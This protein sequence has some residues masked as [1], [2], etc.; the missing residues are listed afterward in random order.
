MPNQLLLRSEIDAFEVG[1]AEKVW[2]IL[3]SPKIRKTIIFK[4]KIG[5][6]RFSRF[7]L[8]S[9]FMTHCIKFGPCGSKSLQINIFVFFNF[10]KSW[11]KNMKIWRSENSH[12]FVKKKTYKNG[13][14]PKS[15]K[16]STSPISIDDFS[17]FRTF[18]CF[19]HFFSLFN[20][21]RIYLRAHEEL[22]GQTVIVTY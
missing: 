20:F 12:F 19:S 10:E 4:H 5:N 6:Y 13:K 18:Q 3:K 8:K 22:V 21:K 11:L 17:S 14:S 15:T 16:L 1:E 9:L 2:K 7:S